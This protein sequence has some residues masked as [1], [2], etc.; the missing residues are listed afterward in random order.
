M[1]QRFGRTALL[2]MSLLAISAVPALAETLRYPA[3]GV[4]AVTAKVPDGWRTKI[5]DAD[6]ALLV[7]AP[8]QAGFL[9][10]N[11]A[12]ITDLG[13]ASDADVA[14]EIF[15]AAKI[16]GDGTSSATQVGGRAA[17]AFP[18]VLSDTDGTLNVTLLVVRLGGDRLAVIVVLINPDAPQP[19]ADALQRFARTLT[20]QTQ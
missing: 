13:S 9:T 5:D 6:Q 16:T 4:P 17:T 1:L 10:V 11:M 15:K 12:E 20:F 7:F 19:S 3:S 8:D 14:V 18:G 2:V